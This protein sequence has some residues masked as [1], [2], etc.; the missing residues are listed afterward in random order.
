MDNW[1]W[2]D[3]TT[4]VRLIKMLAVVQVNLALDN[5]WKGT[6]LHSNFGLEARRWV[7]RAFCNVEIV[8]EHVQLPDGGCLTSLSGLLHFNNLT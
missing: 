8:L 3:D 4:N 6:G 5:D 1:P 7:K 2:P